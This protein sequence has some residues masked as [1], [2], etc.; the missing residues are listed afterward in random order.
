MKEEL[1]LERYVNYLR[2]INVSEQEIEDKVNHEKAHFEKARELGYDFVYNLNISHD[3]G[4]LH[5]ISN[6]V[7]F[8]GRLPIPEHMIQ[9]LLAPE[10]PSESDLHTAR[11]LA[12]KL[13][14]N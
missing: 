5:K 10:K 12:S 11:E 1:N 3:A 8:N 14:T 2:E 9:I 13:K 7:V 4:D 6:E